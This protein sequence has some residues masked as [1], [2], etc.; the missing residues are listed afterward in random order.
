LHGRRLI[1]ACATAVL[2]APCAPALAL[3]PG[4]FIDPHA[5][6]SKEYAFPLQVLRQLAAGHPLARSVSSDTRFG[7]GVTPAATPA[8]GLALTI[9][10]KVAPHGGGRIARGT[11]RTVAVPTREQLAYLTR[12]SSG[13]PGIALLGGLAVALGAGLGL[14]LRGRR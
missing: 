9:P 3:E 10:G 14:A 12:S 4:V 2:L 11:A 7:L 8:G 1:L 5:P 13:L 6:A